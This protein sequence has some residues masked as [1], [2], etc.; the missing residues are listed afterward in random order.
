MMH[1]YALGRVRLGGGRTRQALVALVVSCSS[2]IRRSPQTI[3]S[4][5]ESVVRRRS[6]QTINR[7]ADH[8]KL[9]LT[10]IEHHHTPLSTNSKRKKSPSFL[11][12]ICMVYV[13]GESIIP[14]FAGGESIVPPSGPANV[15]CALPNVEGVFRTLKEYCVLPNVPCDR[16]ST[17]YF[18]TYR[19]TGGV[20]CTSERTVR[21]K[22]YC[23]L[24]NVPCDRRSTV[25]FRT[26]RA[27]AGYFPFPHC[28]R[29]SEEYRRV[30]PFTACALRRS[31]K[32]E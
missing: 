8:L 20:L 28:V 4:H 1:S 2:T 6:S 25:Y 10:N 17:V 30:L 27:T 9:T 19:A 29:S 13:H 23:V 31:R 21:Q 16:R 24:P 26:Y 18:R 11:R 15:Y 12:Q 7:L 22:E 32:I 3:H 14:P 5:C